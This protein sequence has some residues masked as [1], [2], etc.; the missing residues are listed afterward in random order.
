MV[1]RS[2]SVG[3]AE[4]ASDDRSVNSGDDFG[5]SDGFGASCENVTSAHAS[6]GANQA[7]AL[8]TQENLL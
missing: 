4:V 8:Q 7:D 1:A 2:V 6:L 5:Q 3:L